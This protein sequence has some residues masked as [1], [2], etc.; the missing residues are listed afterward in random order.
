[1]M[2]CTALSACASRVKPSEADRQ[3]A[4]T[5]VKVGN[6]TGIDVSCGIKVVYTQGELA[7]IKVKAP[8]YVL[9]YVKIINKKGTLDVS[10]EQSFFKKYNSIDADVTVTCSAP[11]VAD[12]ETSSGA[13]ISVAG[14]LS[15]RGDADIS[16]SSGS[17]VSMPSGVSA[18]GKIEIDASSAANIALGAVKGHSCEMEASSGSGIKVVSMSANRLEIDQSSGSGITLGHVVVKS[19]A[20]D[21]SS[22]AS[23]TLKGKTGAMD[24][25][26]SSGASFSGK[27]F[28]AGNARVEASSGAVVDF[29]SRRASLGDDITASVT[30][31]H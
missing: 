7:P 26:A 10:I 30:N 1:M 13:S 18:T 28:K 17:T 3:V 24:I 8:R 22:G 9:D 19:A 23:C 15:V 27:E 2:L 21:L 12:F 29:N 20:F 6:Y 25:E 11:V 5:S 4:S 14:A 16:A 31:H